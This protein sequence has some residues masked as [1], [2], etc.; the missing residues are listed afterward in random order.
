MF[1]CVTETRGLQGRVYGLVFV[2]AA[3]LIAVLVGASIDFPHVRTI[4]C[5]RR[6]TFNLAGERTSKELAWIIS[7]NPEKQE[8]IATAE[9]LHVFVRDHWGTE[10]KTHNL[11]DGTFHEAANQAS[12]GNG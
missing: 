10:N 7:G 2:L 1:G 11:R 5:I 12:T 4:G 3:S 6:D 9:H 8:R